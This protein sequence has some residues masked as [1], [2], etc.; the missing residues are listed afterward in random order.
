MLLLFW[1][2]LSFLLFLL[3]LFELTPV[4]LLGSF[5]FGCFALGSSTVGEGSAVGRLIGEFVSGPSS[6]S[7]SVVGVVEICG[8]L[9]QQCVLLRSAALRSR[10]F[11]FERLVFSW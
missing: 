11:L 10:T 3:Y 4:L 2:V 7:V 5:S 6:M 8:N 1:L 9:C